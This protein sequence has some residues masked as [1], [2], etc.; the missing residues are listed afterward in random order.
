MFDTF[1]DNRTGRKNKDTKGCLLP[2]SWASELHKNNYF[3]YL[4]VLTEVNWL[5]LALWAVMSVWLHIRGKQ[6]SDLSKGLVPCFLSPFLLLLCE[7]R[8]GAGCLWELGKWEVLAWCEC[9]LTGSFTCRHILCGSKSSV[10]AVHWI[11]LQGKIKS[12]YFR[13]HI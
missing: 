4:S 12:C 8:G 2:L 5:W 7:Q 13:E 3:C 11:C 1:C 9:G 10:L 6:P